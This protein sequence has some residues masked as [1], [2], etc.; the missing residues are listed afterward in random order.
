M[1]TARRGDKGLGNTINGGTAGSWAATQRH[2]A[3]LALDPHQEDMINHG[4]TNAPRVAD[5]WN[6]EG[7]NLIDVTEAYDTAGGRTILLG[8][9][10]SG[11]K[12]VTLKH[13]AVKE[14]LFSSSAGYKQGELM[15]WTLRSAIAAD[16]AQERFGHSPDLVIN[17]LELS[18][19]DDARRGA[20]LM[21]RLGNSDYDLTFTHNYGSGKSNL[22]AFN[23]KS[24]PM[25]LSAAEKQLLTASVTGR[26]TTN[27]QEEMKALFN[28]VGAD[29]RADA[30]ADEHI[31]KALT[32]KEQ[33]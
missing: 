30:D 5:S 23:Y 4:F 17:E 16:A 15:T 11:S 3:T 28:E 22:E 20:D 14:P 21:I 29:V 33:S 2:E 6:G 8:K 13:P 27:F 31:K 7:S 9:D 1:S 26:P 25:L 19:P 18:A 24:G 10:P 32:P 12:A